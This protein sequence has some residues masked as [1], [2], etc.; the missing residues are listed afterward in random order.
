[1]QVWTGSLEAQTLS[2]EEWEW[3]NRNGALYPIYTDLPAAPECILK[4]IKCGCKGDCSTMRCTCK[5]N[6][7]ECFSVCTCKGVS[8]IN[9]L[10]NI[11]EEDSEC[12]Q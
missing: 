12:E 10:R 1:M 7:I 4:M 6:G 8:C 5:K 11:E 3:V 9:S 2:P